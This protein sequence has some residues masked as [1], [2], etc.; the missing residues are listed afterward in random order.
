MIEGWRDPFVFQ[1]SAPG[2]A[3]AYQMILGSGF[4]DA[5]GVKHGTILRYSAARL[6]GPWAYEGQVATGG[7]SEGRVWE[8]PALLAVRRTLQTFDSG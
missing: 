6:E 5:A 2:G 4:R 7:G 1:R 8:C 3:V